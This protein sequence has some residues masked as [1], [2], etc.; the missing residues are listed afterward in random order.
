MVKRDRRR[1]SGKRVVKC[2]GVNLPKGSGGCTSSSCNHRR[3]HKW[4]ASYPKVT[5]NINNCY[6]HTYREILE[7]KSVDRCTCLTKGVLKKV[8][9]LQKLGIITIG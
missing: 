5:I 1:V 3:L 4:I 7:D 8:L 2:V 9:D 6:A